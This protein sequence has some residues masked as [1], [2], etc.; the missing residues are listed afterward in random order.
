MK[1]SNKFTLSRILLSPVFFI[2]YVLP[3]WTGKF[4][5]LSVAIAIPM[6]AFMELSFDGQKYSNSKLQGELGTGRSLKFYFCLVHSLTGPC[7]KAFLK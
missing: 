7:Y 5:E 4:S 2:L 3:I 6:L 1:L